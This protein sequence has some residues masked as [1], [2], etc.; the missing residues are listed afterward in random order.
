VTPHGWQVCTEVRVA[1]ERFQR[2]LACG[3]DQPLK[4]L[5][6]LNEQ[7]Q[8]DPHQMV[9]HRFVCKECVK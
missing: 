4:P 1:G 8:R 9:G 7:A 2:V 3:H 6:F 5:E